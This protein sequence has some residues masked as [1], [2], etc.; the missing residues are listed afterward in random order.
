MKRII[1][2]QDIS[3]VGKCSLTVALPIISAMGTECAVLPTAVLSN[4]T[5]FR[6]F[7]F[8]DLTDEIERTVDAWMEEG[9]IFDMIYTGYLGSFEQIHLVC[10]MIDRLREQNPDLFVVVD[11]AMGD[12]GTL[13]KGFTET[14]AKEMG[15]LCR[16]AD[17][18]LPNLTEAAYLLGI[19][20]RHEGYCETQVKDIL[21]RLTDMG[22]KQAALTGVSTSVDTI[23]VMA[24]HAE[25]E[26][27][28]CYEGTR[29]PVMYHGT[30]DIFAS[31]V[32]GALSVGMGIDAALSLAVD[33]TFACIEQTMKD[34]N[35]R[36]YGVNFE[37]AL[38]ML[39][40]TAK[41]IRT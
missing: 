10:A 21:L 14:F 31:T 9:L 27:Y 1:T 16:K 15:T 30:G 11:P 40:E 5:A 37:S 28:F 6:Q 13:Y 26:R 36:W 12:G 34:P 8:H 33:Y 25:E 22:V 18:I 3:C 17:L 7:T 35:A 39:T 2:V 20:Y 4:H 38:G 29:A 41:K 19:P 32:V 24:Y 23:G